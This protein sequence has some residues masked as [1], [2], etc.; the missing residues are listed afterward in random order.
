LVLCG[1]ARVTEGIASS[2]HGCLLTVRFRDAHRVAR[3]WVLF[4]GITVSLFV[5]IL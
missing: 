4:G 2:G 5:P 3:Q 1:D